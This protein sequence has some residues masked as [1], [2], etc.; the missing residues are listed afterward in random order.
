MPNSSQ[1]DKP[2]EFQSSVPQGKSGSLQ[3]S[4][5]LFDTANDREQLKYVLD[6]IG[7]VYNNQSVPEKA[8]DYHNRSATLADTLQWKSGK[9][10]SEY[11]LAKDYYV[12]RDYKTAKQ[13]NDDALAFLNTQFDIKPISES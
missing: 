3:K 6:E 2:F 9:A 10:I 8:I 11:L 13:F 7:S 4:L 5:A 12:K 1:I